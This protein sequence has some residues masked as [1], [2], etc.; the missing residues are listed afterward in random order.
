[1]EYVQPYFLHPHNEQKEGHSSKNFLPSPFPLE[2]N[3][4][5]YHV[6]RILQ[7]FMNHIAYFLERFVH[8]ES[9]PS[10]GKMRPH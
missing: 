5:Y 1:M 3:G 6:Q 4:R 9:V 2:R 10:L 7:L 8:L